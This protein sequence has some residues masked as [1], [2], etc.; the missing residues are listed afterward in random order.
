M[1]EAE[2]IGLTQ[3]E[4]VREIPI[5]DLVDFHD[6]PFRVPDETD[7]R[8]IALAESIKA[9]GVLSPGIVQP[10]SNGKYEIISGH[11]RKKASRLAGLSTMPVIVKNYPDEEAATT[12]LLDANLQRENIL[13]S[14]KAKAYSARYALIKHQGRTEIEVNTLKGVEKIMGHSLDVIAEATGESPKTVQR[15]IF[16]SRLIDELLYMIDDKKLPLTIG[17]SMASLNKEQQKVL[18]KV[19]SGPENITINARHITAIKHIRRKLTEDIARKI[20]LSNSLAKPTTKR[21]EVSL[22]LN[23][24]KKYIPEDVTN[25]EI[26]NR[27]YELFEKYGMYD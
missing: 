13:P 11:R 26:Q 23:R 7:T 8:I 21:K 10:L 14:E 25:R 2:N 1:F 4:E 9:N 15:Y 6:H 12:A 3:G 22:P 24:I 19:I 17:L 18:Y 5:D 27:V 16:L 20:L